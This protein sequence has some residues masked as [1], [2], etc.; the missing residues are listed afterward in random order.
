MW[1]F[2]FAPPMNCRVG[3]SSAVHS[4]AVLLFP[5][6]RVTVVVFTLLFMACSGSSECDLTGRTLTNTSLRPLNHISAPSQRHR[7]IT[8]M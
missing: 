4:M 1:Q 5:E 7:Y 2:Q 8:I 6:V 3:A